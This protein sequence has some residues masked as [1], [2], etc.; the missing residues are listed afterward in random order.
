M[1][2][3]IFEAEE[4]EQLEKF[5]DPESIKGIKNNN[6]KVAYKDYKIDENYI[7]PPS[8]NDYIGPTHIARVI[9]KIIDKIDLSFIEKKFKGGGTPAYHPSMLLKV[10]ILGCLYKIYTGRS[11]EKA[12]RENIVF[13]WLSGNQ[14]PNF[15][16]LNNFH[17]KL[18]GGI[19]K[20]FKAVLKQIMAMGLIDGKDVFVDHTK[21]LANNNKHK[22]TWRKNVEKQ[23]E[24]YEQEIDELFKYIKRLNLK[25]DNENNNPT[26]EI[27][28]FDETLLDQA[29]DQINEEI[30]NK[31]RD[32][33][34]GGEIKKKIRRAKEVIKKKAEYEEKKKILGTR[35][36][37][38]NTDHDASG[39]RQKDKKTLASS[40]NEGIVTNM[41]FV[42]AYLISSNAA[43][44]YSFIELMKKLE[45]NM[46]KQ[47]LAVHSDSAYG[48]EENMTWLEKMCIA[49]Y[50]KYNTYEREKGR[51]WYRDKVRKENFIYEKEKDRYRC[52]NGGYL[53]FIEECMKTTSTGF[54]KLVRIYRAKE[55]DCENC[56]FKNECTKANAR[57]LEVSP[58]FERLKRQARDNLSSVKGKDLRRR[59]GFEIETV[60]GDKKHNNGR[61]RYRMRGKEKIEV[62][63]G[64]YYTAYNL[65]KL[66]NKVLKMLTGSI[67]GGNYIPQLKSS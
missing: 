19:K 31:K 25:E 8:T 12:L 44:N 40:Y 55:S 49:N 52:I 66:Y 61:F 34:E 47:P 35:N 51:Q 38:S 54:E 39:M 10:W 7:F 22:I 28:E 16:T 57:S 32:R 60:F 4:L 13:I 29:I 58:N 15:R 20:V 42:L 24:K 45:S 56:P 46:G 1:S 65:K 6:K 5:G 36:S 53:T 30:K 37:F 18:E 43:D 33:I 48:T 11:L 14:Q 27:N 23:L 17:R 9:N 2:Q 67:G 59:R 62:E 63:L 41:G 3:E 50:L 21:T 26:M 64:L